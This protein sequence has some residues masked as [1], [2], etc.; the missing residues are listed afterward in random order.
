[1]E[2]AAVEAAAVEAAAVEAAVWHA[3]LLATVE[4]DGDTVAFLVLVHH[5]ADVQAAA[6]VLS[7]SQD[8]TGTDSL[9]L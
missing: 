3:A 5:T 4:N 9:A 7:S 8:A 1:M 2:A 6:F